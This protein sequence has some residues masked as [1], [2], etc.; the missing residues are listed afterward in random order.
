MTVPLD[1]PELPGGPRPD[2]DGPVRVLLADDD[3]LVRAGIAGILAT[4]PGIEVAAEAADDDHPVAR[5]RA[6]HGGERRRDPRLLAV[7]HGSVIE[8]VPR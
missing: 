4:S 2:R 8:H 6:R 5:D 3:G 7:E 1:E